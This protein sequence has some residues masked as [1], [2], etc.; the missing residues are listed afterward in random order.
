MNGGEAAIKGS[1]ASEAA[2]DWRTVRDASDIQF[3]P[4]DIKPPPTLV[5]A[6][7]PEWIKA[8]GRFLRWIFE[9]FGEQLDVSWGAFSWV[10]SGLAV[11]AVLLLV[12]RLLVPLLRDRKVVPAEA[13]AQWTPDRDA[14]L[15][16]LED[17]D[18][19]AAEGRFDEAAH[20]LLRRSVG[21]IAEAQPD[22]LRPASTAREIAELPCLP[23]LAREAFALIAGRV[24][25]SFFAL[26]PLGADDWEAARAAYAEFALADIR[27]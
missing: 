15:S 26:I 24:E 16:L 1:R 8:V 19:L 22:W 9:P 23:A 13:A 6:E 27:A 2:G 3:S 4:I 12:W 10:L 21:Q 20:L 11:V 7:P 17:A 25:R 18:R 14:V 5:P